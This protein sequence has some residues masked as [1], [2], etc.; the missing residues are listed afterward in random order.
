[1]E[2][3]QPGTTHLLDFLDSPIVRAPVHHAPQES[4][5]VISCG[6][7]ATLGNTSGKMARVSW[8]IAGGGGENIK[9]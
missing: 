8:M 1:M 5:M 7:A 2:Y 3:V 4:L 6:Y 9:G